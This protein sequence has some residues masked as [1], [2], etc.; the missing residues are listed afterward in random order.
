M[1][2]ADHSAFVAIGKAMAARNGYKAE[3]SSDLYITDGDQIDWMYGRQRIFSFTWEL[4]PPETPTVWG[5]HYPADEK[6]APQTARN[7]SAL[8][9]FLTSRAARTRAIGRT[10]ADCGPFFDDTEI[11]RGWT[12]NPDGTDTAPAAPGSSAATRQPTTL[13]TARGSSR[14]GVLRPLRVRHRRAWP[15]S[16]PN[17][18]DLDGADDDPERRRSRCRRRPGALSFRYVLRPRPEQHRRTRSRSASRTRRRADAGLVRSTA[19]RARSGPRW[20]TGRG[21]R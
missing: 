14:R 1:T 7:R 9:Y 12:V 10:Q 17:A 3:Q 4:Y 13:S 6:I 2:V 18:Y 15:A 19:R 20:V 21:R 8:L 11:T 16:P 5:D